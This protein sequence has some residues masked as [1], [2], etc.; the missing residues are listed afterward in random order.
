MTATLEHEPV[1]I[2]EEYQTG[3]ATAG[4][5]MDALLEGHRRAA[6]L[7]LTLDD[8]SHVTVP[9]AALGLLADILR[10]MGRGHAVTIVPYGAELTTQQVADILNVSRPYV[11][12]LIETGE[13]PG[14]KVGPRRRVRFEDLMGYKRADDERRRRVAQDLTREAEDLGLEY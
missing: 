7:T 12:K 6:T 14:R 2:A 9:V 10:E 3:A 5:R 4:D 13:L 1:A 11:V 8:E